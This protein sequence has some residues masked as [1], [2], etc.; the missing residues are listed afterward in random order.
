VTEQ[1]RSDIINE[2]VCQIYTQS[3][4]TAGE[5]LQHG[6]DGLSYL[7]SACS[8]PDWIADEQ[9]KTVLKK[10]TAFFKSTKSNDMESG[11]CK[12]MEKR[13]ERKMTILIAEDEENIIEIL[14]MYLE[15]SGYAVISAINGKMALDMVQD[16]KVDLAIVD[17]MMPVM[18][19]FE[20]IR[21]IRERS[22][23]PIIILSAK[24]EDSD[25]ILGLGIGADDYIAKPFNPLEV[26]ARVNAA[27][28]RVNELNDLQ[29]RQ[30]NKELL[31]R[32]ELTIDL[33]SMQFFK[34]GEEILLTPT[35]FRIMLL[36]MRSPGRV[37]TK[38]QISDCLSESYSDRD[39][40]SITVHISKLREKIEK[41]SRRPE[42]LFTVRGIGYKFKG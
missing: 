5:A 42:Y 30:E 27:L 33:R 9:Q 12:V 37:Y 4:R 6:T 10:G 1:A 3:A 34:N 25:K 2:T 18:N 15:N 26:V 31:T 22:T 38:R 8:A 24:R 13:E 36:M 35:E 39:D 40:S 14:T 28:R 7:R 16:R 29:N 17:V 41:D 19:G 32:G 20:L 21:R 23:L 11:R